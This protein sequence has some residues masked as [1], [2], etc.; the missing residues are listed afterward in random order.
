MSETSAPITA[1]LDPE[2]LS[3]RARPPRAIRFKRGADGRGWTA[4]QDR[5]WR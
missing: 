1:K 4:I 5:V 2:S 3:I